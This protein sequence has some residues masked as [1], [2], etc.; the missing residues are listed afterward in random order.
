MDAK[1]RIIITIQGVDHTPRTTKL[2]LPSFLVSEVKE[3][4]QIINNKQTKA[5]DI[6]IQKHRGAV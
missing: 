2:T 1:D 4:C 3:E 6:A 5:F